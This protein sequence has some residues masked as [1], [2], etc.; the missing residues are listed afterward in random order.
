[1]QDRVSKYSAWFWEK[2]CFLTAYLHV[3]AMLIEIV[4][5]ILAILISTGGLQC[6]TNLDE[7]HKIWISDEKV[8]HVMTL[9][10]HGFT[11]FLGPYSGPSDDRKDTPNEKL[12]CPAIPLQKDI[13]RMQMF[14]NLA[15][16]KL[17]MELV[18]KAM[19]QNFHDDMFNID[20]SWNSE[21]M[22]F[23]LYMFLM[24]SVY[25]HIKFLKKRT[26]KP[27]TTIVIMQSEVNDKVE[28]KTEQP[29]SEQKEDKPPAY[30]L[31]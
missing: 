3:I 29:I 12:C 18:Y 6:N 26:S 2:W 14:L 9:G 24:T 13:R 1:M 31:V 30:A 27:P 10:V 21:L 15:T 22:N 8:I 16:I 17:L 25:Y 28:E 4:F 7:L 19:R 20:V 5:H 11:P 23:F